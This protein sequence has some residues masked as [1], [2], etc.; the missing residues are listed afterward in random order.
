MHPPDDTQLS[1]NAEGE[2]LM[3]TNRKKYRR[4]KIRNQPALT[5]QIPRADSGEKKGGGKWEA[6]HFI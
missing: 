1:Q 3:H 4:Y 6:Q 5:T 2:I